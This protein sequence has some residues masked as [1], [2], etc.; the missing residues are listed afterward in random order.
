VKALVHI[1]VWLTIGTGAMALLLYRGIV[2]F[3]YPD[4][5]AYPIQGVDVSHHQGEIDWTALKGPAVR[6]AYIKASEGATFR[7]PRF[8]SNW[9]A[10]LT[11]GVTPGAYHFFTLCKTGAEQARNFLDALADVTGSGLPPAVDLEF[12]GN[13]EHRPAQQEFMR[14]LHTFLEQVER[15]TGCTPVLYVT[16]DF[17][18][19]YVAGRIEGYPLWVRN[20]YTTPRLLEGADWLLWQHANHGR[21]PGVGTFIDLNVYRGSA[22]AFRDFRCVQA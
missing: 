5:R 15:V 10:A 4:L 7:D 1:A 20:I 6:F 22:A 19:P 21:M 16:Q 11:A 13:C 18:R 3:N 17:Y 12:G 2:R 9:Q 8:A 14:E